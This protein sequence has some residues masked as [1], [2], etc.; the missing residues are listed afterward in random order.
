MTGGC[1]G[2]H[3]IVSYVRDFRRMIW[4]LFAP[5]SSDFNIR[6]YLFG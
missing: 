3:A 4:L 5:M 2:F 1:A 6:D